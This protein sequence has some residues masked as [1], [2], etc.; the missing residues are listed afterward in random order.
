MDLMPLPFAHSGENV[1]KCQ[2]TRLAGQ[3]RGKRLSIRLSQ[4]P[5]QGGKRISIGQS[6]LFTLYFRVHARRTQD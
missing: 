5:A 4:A 6:S 1:S 2:T 3:N